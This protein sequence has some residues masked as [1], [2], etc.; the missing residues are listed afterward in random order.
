MALAPTPEHI[1]RLK[2]WESVSK[3]SFESDEKWFASVDETVSR[4]YPYKK[5]EDAFFQELNRAQG[6]YM[7]ARA[8]L[9]AVS[10]LYTEYW[11]RVANLIKT[12]L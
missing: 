5:R 2:E 3:M 4:C 7:Q 8:A 12:D 1:Q 11:K 10:I 6:N 9:A